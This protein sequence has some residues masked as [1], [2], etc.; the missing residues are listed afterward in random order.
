MPRYEFECRHGH[1]TE[2][3]FP[4]GSTVQRVSCERC[5]EKARRIVSRT[6]FV[7]SGNGWAKDGYQGGKA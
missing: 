5:S 7:L 2:K 4:A 1:V 6:A 3:T